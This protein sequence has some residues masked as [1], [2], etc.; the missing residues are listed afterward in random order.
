[1]KNIN[2]KLFS[3]KDNHFYVF[4][5]FFFLFLYFTYFFRSIYLLP[6]WDFLDGEFTYREIRKHHSSIFNLEKT[7]PILL[8]LWL[9]LYNE[10]HFQN[11]DI[12]SIDIFSNKFDIKSEFL[13][14]IYNI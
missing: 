6:I 9:T 1:M 11:D 3:M 4:L 14:Y 5:F 13:Y 8:D 7:I 10:F 12:F 2:K